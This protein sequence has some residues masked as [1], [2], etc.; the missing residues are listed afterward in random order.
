MKIKQTRQILSGRHINAYSISYLDRRGAEKEWQMVSRGGDP[1]CVTG[2]FDLPD[3]VVI[4]PF[5][6][7]KQ[8]LVIIKE[9]RVA[10]GGF[11]FGFPAGLLDEGESIEE[12]G[13]RELREETGLHLNRVLKQSP[14]I[15]SS[16]GLTDEA[17]SMV[18]AEC[19][20]QASDRGNESSEMI[21][22]LFVSPEEAG[23]LCADPQLKFDVKTWLV[24]SQY[25]VYGPRAVQAE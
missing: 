10:L 6:T 21:T 3:A 11:Q 14:P 2:N 1:K 13:R 23:R 19:S 5:H 4:V 17:V 12:A 7:E 24:L 22:T 25:A 20:G 15:Y 18:F 8:K 9:F 16:S